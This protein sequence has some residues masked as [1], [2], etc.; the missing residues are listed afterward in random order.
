MTGFVEMYFEM[1]VKNSLSVV[2]R[3]Y[4]AYEVYIIE[5][6]TADRFSIFIV[7]VYIWVASLFFHNNGQICI[8]MCLEDNRIFLR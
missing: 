5:A 8:E 7:Y 1:T 6:F 4:I 3:V 2:R